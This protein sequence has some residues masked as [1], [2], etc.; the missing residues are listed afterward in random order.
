MLKLHLSQVVKGRGPTRQNF[1]QS[2]DFLMQKITILIARIMGGWIKDSLW[3]ICG[4]LVAECAENV[5]IWMYSEGPPDLVM[6]SA[7]PCYT[8]VLI[9]A[10]HCTV[11]RI[12]HCAHCEWAV[13]GAPN[14]WFLWMK[15]NLYGSIL[16]KTCWHF[17]G[18]AERGQLF[19][20]HVKRF[21][22]FSTNFYSVW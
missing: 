8:I 17:R 11:S 21:S 12:D 22:Q 10:C 20:C 5:G 16:V 14:C 15:L 18:W 2:V 19:T 7:A 3:G 9:H 13:S 4:V 1:P 6:A